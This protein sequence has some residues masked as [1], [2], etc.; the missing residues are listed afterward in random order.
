VADVIIGSPNYY[1]GEFQE[2][3]AY[4]Y[5]GPLTESPAAGCPD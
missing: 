4:A 5:H 1:N 3:R 2:G